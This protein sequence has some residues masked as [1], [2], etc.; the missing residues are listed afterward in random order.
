[1]TAISAYFYGH[2]VMET[3]GAAWQVA[4]AVW[5]LEWWQALSLLF[6]YKLSF[7][8]LGIIIGFGIF[9]LLPFRL[10]NCWWT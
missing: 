5:H 3:V 1:M 6:A 8:I 7:L 2:W 4:L 10:A 9:Y